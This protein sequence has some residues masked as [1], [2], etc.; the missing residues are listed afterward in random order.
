MIPLKIQVL[1]AVHNQSV[2]S[3]LVSLQTDLVPTTKI[4]VK[5]CKHDHN[6]NAQYQ[7]PLTKGKVNFSVLEFNSLMMLAATIHTRTKCNITQTYVYAH[8]QFPELHK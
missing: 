7:S 6:F 4:V 1:I 5:K 2:S 8:T 3:H